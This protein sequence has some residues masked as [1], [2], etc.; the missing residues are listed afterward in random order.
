MKKLAILMSALIL[1]ALTAGI[2]S[3][4]EKKD[5][6]APTTAAS[7]KLEMMSGEVMNIDAAAGTIVIKAHN[8][9]RT[10]TAE[11]KLLEGFEAGE[12]VQ[13]ETTGNMLKS[14]KKVEAPA[15][16]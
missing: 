4:T 2:G 8:K 15:I 9:D 13:I 5:V 6:N 10:L 1:M 3:A 7:A 11:P 12:M 14:I 16:R